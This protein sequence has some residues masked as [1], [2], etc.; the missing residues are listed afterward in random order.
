MD[1]DP[2]A[3]GAAASPPPQAARSSAPAA[4]TTARLRRLVVTTMAPPAVRDHEHR[5]RH[6]RFHAPRPP[7]SHT[8]AS[9]PPGQQY[10]SKVLVD[11][12]QARAARAD[13]YVPG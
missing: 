3:P 1:S 12:L 8:V 6:R 13:Q 5:T 10:G 7:W 2:S 11:Q 4:T 9:T